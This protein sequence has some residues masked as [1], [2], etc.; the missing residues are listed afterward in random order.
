MN[1]ISGSVLF[2]KNCEWIENLDIWLPIQLSAL[3][4]TL[5]HL[6]PT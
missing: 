4:S 6:Q 3:K 2:G 1:L 5:T